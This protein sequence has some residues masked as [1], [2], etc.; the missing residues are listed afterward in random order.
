MFE[1]AELGLPLDG[2][3]TFDML[4]SENEPVTTGH[5]DGVVTIDLAE[6]DD[7]HREAVRAQMAEPYRTVLGHLRHEVGHYY[8]PIVVADW[9]A[10]RALFG[11]E[12][13]DYQAGAEPPLR[14][15]RARRL[16]RALRQRLRDHAPV[17]GLGRDVR[18]LPAHRR[19]AADRPGLRRAR[20]RARRACW[21]RPAPADGAFASLMAGWLPLTYALNALNRS[22]G[23]EDLYP[24]VLTP[25]VIEKL[26]FVHQSVVGYSKH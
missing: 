14:A 11:D 10:C 26:E 9:D 23:A 16:A 22:M 13:E 20:G 1:L 17:G 21:R 24:F 2:G 3:L 19:H 6:V 18:P 15:G 4:S 5:A 8:Q 7:A 12:R 25:P